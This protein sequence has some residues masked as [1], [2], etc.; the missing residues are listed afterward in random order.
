MRDLFT[1]PPPWAHAYPPNLDWDLEA[2]AKPVYALLDEAAAKDPDAVCLDFLDRHTTF[3]KMLA[4]TNRTARGLQQ[5][6]VQKGDRVGLCLPNSPYY[7]AAYFGVLKAGATV[8]N[9]NPLYTED[10]I[11]AQIADAGVSIMFTLDLK[12]LYP[13]VAAALKGTS[14]RNIVVC[15]LS[16][17]L[18]TVKSWLFQVFKRGEIAAPPHNLQNLPFSWL[19]KN[20]GNYDPVEIDPLSDIALFQYTGGTTG[21][22]KAAMLTHSNII[23]NTEQVRGWLTDDDPD[24]ESILA[25]LPFFHVFAMTVVMCLGL[26]I[27]AKLI[28]LPRFELDQ[29]LKTIHEKRPSLFPAVPT[30]YGAISNHPNLDRYDLTSIRHCIAGGAPLPV[31][32][33]HAFEKLTGCVLVEGYGLTEASPVVCCNPPWGDNKPG[34]IGIPL[35]GTHVEIRDLDN[36]ARTVP[37][38]ERGEV[39]VRGPQVMAGYWGR[40]EETLDVLEGHWLRTGDVG[41]LDE[42]GYVFLTDRMKDVILC[43]GYNVYPRV[44]EDALYQHPDVLE[45]VVIAIP[46]GYR[47]ETPKAFVKLAEDAKAR[48]E[49]L[50][51]FCT[52]HL[53]PLERP[54]EIELRDELPKTLIGKL[55]KK[56][57]VEEEAQKRREAQPLQELRHG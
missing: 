22:P 26:R 16:D 54:E 37:I 55:S 35:P 30:I 39:V 51:A 8:V 17:A 41:H 15:S 53:N 18:P 21:T 25:V 38:G 13:K 28:A 45:A 14:L 20:L 33:K 52:E 44:I 32:I 12:S 7:I 23:T 2:I 19:T 49:D 42:D 10:E 46:H 34:A 43:G 31:E 56:E 24:G 29:V 47:G 1:P 48:P 4:L 40:E 27:R 6:G 36:K 57:L 3:A 5:L 9:F 50:M 11:R